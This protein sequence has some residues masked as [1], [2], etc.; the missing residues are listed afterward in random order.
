ME[1]GVPGI[2]AVVSVPNHANK[3]SGAH[4][5]YSAEQRQGDGGNC[6]KE[7]KVVR[8]ANAEICQVNVTSSSSSSST[9]MDWVNA[10]AG[11]SIEWDGVVMKEVGLKKGRKRGRGEERA[12]GRW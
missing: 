11:A 8:K 1:T 7:N 2:Q 9:M 10:T 4:V 12:V 3:S 5:P 6:V